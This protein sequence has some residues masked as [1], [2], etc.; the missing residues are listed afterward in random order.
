M[1]RQVVSA[2]IMPRAGALCIWTGALGG[3]IIGFLLST[4]LYHG[5]LF[6][7][8]KGTAGSGVVLGVLPFLILFF[9]GCLLS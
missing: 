7:F 2:S 4:G 5:H 6:Q 9:I 8:A 3:L 1:D